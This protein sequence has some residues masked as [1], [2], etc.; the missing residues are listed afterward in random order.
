MIQPNQLISTHSFLSLPRI[1]ATVTLITGMVAATYAGVTISGPDRVCPGET[2]TWTA[3]HSGVILPCTYKWWILRN[4]F[5]IDGPK[6]G[7]SVSFTMGNTQETLT[8][9]AVLSRGI[10]CLGTTIASKTVTVQLVAP[11]VIQ[12]P[13]NLCNGA[14]ADFYVNEWANN[15]SDCNFHYDNEWSVPSGWTIVSEW[16]TL[17]PTRNWAR[18]K[19]PAS[20]SGNKQIKVRGIN[21]PAGSTPY[22]T[23]TVE[24]GK[25]STSNI[26]ASK[27][28]PVCLN[29][30]VDFL[31]S[32]SGAGEVLEYDWIYSSFEINLQINAGMGYQPWM[33]DYVDKSAVAATVNNFQNGGVTLNLRTRNTCGWSGYKQAYFMEDPFNCGGF[34]LTVFPNP[35]NDQLNIS[36]EPQTKSVSNEKIIQS[37][38]SIAMYNRY[39]R[40]VREITTNKKNVTINTQK[41]PK[42]LYSI[43]IHHNEGVLQ[44]KV[45][46]E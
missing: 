46:L 24:L 29:G 10:G 9:R 18:I 32:Y 19:A 26:S 44:K 25:P 2:Y 42:G 5:A 23:K 7:S 16:N 28:G 40:L 1:F 31:A 13:D 22:R 11:P 27:F 35:A 14:T 36:L 45:L 3:S 34:F 12:G 21:H 8:V 41:L 43:S 6:S 15:L 4:G 30:Q 20:G 17:N 38:Y 37:D 33:P 39:G